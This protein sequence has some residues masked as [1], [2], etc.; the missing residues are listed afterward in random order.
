MR[1][2]PVQFSEYYSHTR[3]EEDKY[4]QTNRENDS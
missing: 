2:T 1:V 3:K 4:R